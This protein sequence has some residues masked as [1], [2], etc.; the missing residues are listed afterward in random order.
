MDFV[1]MGPGPL[2][3]LSAQETAIA[4]LSRTAIASKAV[5]PPPALCSHL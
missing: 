4:I 5:P 1:L 2:D 3:S